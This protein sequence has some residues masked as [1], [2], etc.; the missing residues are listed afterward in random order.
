MTPEQKARQEIDRQLEACGW[1]V[2]DFRRMNISASLGVAVREFP[3]STG[4]VDY[5]L[6]ADGKICR[7]TFCKLRQTLKQ[8]KLVLDWRKKLRTRADVY[9]TVKTVLDDLPRIYTPELYQEKC[10]LVYRHVFYAYQG[11]GKS[12]YEAVEA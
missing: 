2:Q 1:Q 9:S 7:Q 6:Y 11:E 5:L 8:A 4:H 3:L 12:I 10:D